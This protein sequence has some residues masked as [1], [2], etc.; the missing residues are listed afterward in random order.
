MCSIEMVEEKYQ[1]KGNVTVTGVI[2]LPDK[3]VHVM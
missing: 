2:K 3:I 1:L